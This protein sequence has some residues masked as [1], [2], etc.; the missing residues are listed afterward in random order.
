MDRKRG[1]EL[2]GLGNYRLDG[3]IGGT[4]ETLAKNEGR[5]IIQSY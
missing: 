3:G 4:K 5:D 2:D 1:G